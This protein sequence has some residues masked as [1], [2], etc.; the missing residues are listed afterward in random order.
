[1][2][3]ML[4]EAFEKCI[5]CSKRIID[6]YKQNKVEFLLKACN[7]PDYLEDVTGITEMMA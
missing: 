1:M 2:N 5:G 4:G 6:E 7:K 3:V